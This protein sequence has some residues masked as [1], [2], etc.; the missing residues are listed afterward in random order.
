MTEVYSI[1]IRGIQF[2]Q[3]NTLLKSP[4]FVTQSRVWP[5]SCLEHSWW[6]VVGGGGWW[7]VVVGG[8]G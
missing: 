8:G 5:R 1:E 2:Q 4:L 7:W 6:V 3:Q